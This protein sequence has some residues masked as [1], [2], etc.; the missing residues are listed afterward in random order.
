MTDA[1]EAAAGHHSTSLDT[2]I[3]DAKGSAHQL[4]DTF[5]VRD[6]RFDL[7]DATLTIAEAA[8]ELPGRERL[9]KLVLALYLF[10]DR[11]HSQIAS[12]IAISQM[13]VSRIP[14]RTL[15]RLRS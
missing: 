2:P 11:T 14:K 3:D 9:A 12:E 10:E 13:Q 4:A 1:L 5:V 15:E 6:E 8:A 7:I